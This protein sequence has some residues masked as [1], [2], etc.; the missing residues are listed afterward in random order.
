MKTNRRNFFN[1]IFGIGLLGWLGSLLYPLI[2][3]LNPPKIAEAK[4]SSVKAGS[5]SEFRPNSAKIIKFGRKPVILIRTAMGDF[6]AFSATCTHLDCIVQYS[7][8][9]KLIWCACHN[10]TYNLRGQN[11]SGP[12]P[13]PLEEFDVRII[14]DEIMVSQKA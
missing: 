10:G 1:Y 6:R 9:R 2:D 8:E 7:Q 14:N 3:Y 12:P 5:S 4:V 11:I 13:R